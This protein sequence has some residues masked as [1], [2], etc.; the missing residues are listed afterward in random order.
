MWPTFVLQVIFLTTSIKIT[1][2]VALTT[3]EFPCRRSFLAKQVSLQK[4]LPCKTSLQ[5]WI[6]HFANPH[7]NKSEDFPAM[8]GS[9]GAYPLSI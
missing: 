5:N 8:T 4:E 6:L 2:S 1:V 3:S 7:L 9:L